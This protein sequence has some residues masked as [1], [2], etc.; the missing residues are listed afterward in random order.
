VILGENL[1]FDDLFGTYEPRSD[2]KLRNLLSQA[3]V[4]RD[5]SPGPEFTRAAQCRAELHAALCTGCAIS[6]SDSL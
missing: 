1:S 4:N 6:G 3:I 2:A 5:G